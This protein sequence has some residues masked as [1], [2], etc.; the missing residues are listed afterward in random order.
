[1]DQTDTSAGLAGHRLAK[2]LA[3]QSVA[4]VG[5]SPKPETVG[6]GMLRGL[7]GGGFKGHVYPVNPNYPDIEGMRCYPSLAALPERVDHVLLGV[8]N[9]RLEDG[10]RE[11]ASAGVSAVTILASGYL[12]TDVVPPL[13]RRLAQLARGAGMQVCGG[14]GMGFYNNEAGVRLCGFPP[15]DWVGSGPIALISHSGSAFSALVHND[16]R[17]GH[18]LA[19]S[20]GQELVTTAADY[21]DYA[22][23]M[24]RTRVVGLFLETI[25]DPAGFI[26]GLEL[27]CKRDVPVVVLKVGRTAESAALALTHSGALVGDDAV[28]RALFRRHGVIQ[29]DDLDEFANALLLFSQPRRLAAGG[30]ASIHDSGGERELLVDLAAATKVRFASISDETRNKLAALLDYGLKPTNPLDAWGTGADYERIFGAC[31]SAL[32]ADPA[33]AIGAFCV[34]TRTGKAL[35]EAYARAMERAHA[36]SDK[37]VVFVNNLAALGDDELAVQITRSGIPVLIGLS[38]ALAAIKGAML[39]RDFRRRPPSMPPSAPPGLR[40]RWAA[41][42]SLGTVLDEAES[43]ELISDYCLPVIAHRI[44][45]EFGAAATAARELGYPVALKTAAPGIIHKSDKG[46]V[47]LGIADGNALRAAYEELANRLGPRMLVAAMA[48][49]GVEL[50]LGAKLDPSFGAAVMIGA[51]GVLIESLV[52]RTHALAPFDVTEAREL[53]D[54][55]ELRVLLEG[56]RGYPAADIESLAEV[57]ARFSVMVADLGALVSEIDVNPVLA[58]PAGPIA[59]DALVIPS[60]AVM[61]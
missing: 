56:N 1:M 48:P 37:P 58:G 46:G 35:H 9:A 36:G 15:P 38:P 24:P 5:A 45:E 34:E 8:A 14:N 19:V 42:L 6:N 26:S 60:S 32:L 22:L 7:L 2:L 43:L 17:F 28:Q 10:M 11:A 12:E 53:I 31:M 30:L 51:G 20:A 57:L 40:D 23:H 25:R 54:L 33:T 59:L 3:P 16:R 44:V 4:L 55:L 49:M 61:T 13:T 27:A 39:R 41:R 50:S 18:C 21:L 47:R 52:D 29:V